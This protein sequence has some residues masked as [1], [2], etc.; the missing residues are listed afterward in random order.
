VLI[1]THNVR[2]Y[3]DWMARIRAALESGRLASLEAPPDEK[4][5]AED[6]MSGEVLS[7]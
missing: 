6:R 1:S 3:L 4:L 5:P 2:F 7:G